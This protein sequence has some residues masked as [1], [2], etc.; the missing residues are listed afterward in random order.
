MPYN[1]RLVWLQLPSLELRRIRKDLIM[2][3]KI[4][5]S[6]VAL[7]LSDFVALSNN[8][9]TRG[10]N[11]KLF[12]KQFCLDVSKYFFSNRVIDMWNNLPEACVSSQTIINF[13]RNLMLCDLNLYL[14]GSHKR[15]VEVPG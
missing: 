3:Y 12:K 1:D 8:S 4:M 9:R 5:H 6:H 2:C 11:F 10:H 15:T 13:K 7:E 14:R